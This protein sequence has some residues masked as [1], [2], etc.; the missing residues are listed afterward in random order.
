M[1]QRLIFSQRG[2]RTVV[3]KCPRHELNMVKLGKYGMIFVKPRAKLCMSTI[4]RVGNGGM[5]PVARG[6]F[7]CP[8]PMCFLVAPLDE[9][10]TIRA[11]E[12]VDD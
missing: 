1:V 8:F 11:A 4:S 12:V 9:S 3:P 6:I 10:A 7:R 2:I 5:L